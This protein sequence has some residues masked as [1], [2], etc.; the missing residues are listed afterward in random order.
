MRFW[1]LPLL[2]LLLVACQSATPGASAPAGYP[3]MGPLLDRVA[4]SLQAQEAA[5]AQFQ[6]TA[7][8]LSRWA[9]PGNQGLQTLYDATVTDYNASID[10]AVTMGSSVDAVDAAANTIFQQW[11]IEIEVYTDPVLKAENKAKLEASWQR[12]ASLIQV[13]RQTTGQVNPVLAQLNQDVTHLR[14]NLNENALASRQRELEATI[15]AIGALVEQI[16]AA[17]S[18]SRSYIQSMQ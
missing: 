15:N 11:Q 12:Y 18:A 1:I 7:Q 5:A 2:S 13:L 6:S 14:Q 4:Q 8:Q 17:A 10:A 16:N 3:A 9:N